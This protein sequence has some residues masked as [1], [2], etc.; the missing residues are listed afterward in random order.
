M[1]DRFCMCKR[2]GE[3][4]DHLLLHCEVACSILNVFFTRFGLSWALPRRV[5]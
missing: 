3:F 4:V 5:V 2:S 1:D